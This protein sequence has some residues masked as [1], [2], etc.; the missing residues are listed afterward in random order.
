MSFN[1]EENLEKVGTKMLVRYRKKRG[2]LRKRR[3][4]T[5]C[6]IQY[7]FYD[8]HTLSIYTDFENRTVPRGKP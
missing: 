5:Q 7:R 4:Q 1:P 8:I 6:S 3:Y 2:K